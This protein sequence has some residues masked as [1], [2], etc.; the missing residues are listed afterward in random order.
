MFS[1]LATRTGL[2]FGFLRFR[3]I[4][5]RPTG[6]LDF[7]FEQDHVK[8]PAN[9]CI[10]AKELCLSPPATGRPVRPA[11]LSAKQPIQ[12]GSPKP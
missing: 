1:T 6:F 10:P 12:F 9:V 5:P 7:G 2:C 11:N 4:A 8:T 3:V